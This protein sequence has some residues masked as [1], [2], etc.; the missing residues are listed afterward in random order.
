ML[1]CKYFVTPA[2]CGRGTSCQYSH[3]D[4]IPDGMIARAIS[5]SLAVFE[6]GGQVYKVLVPSDFT[7]IRITGLP[8]NATIGF[9]CILRNVPASADEEDILTT[10]DEK[11]TPE[12]LDFSVA[13]YGASDEMTTRFEVMTKI[14]L[15]V[16]LQIEADENLLIEQYIKI[17]AY[18]STDVSQ[19]FTSLKIEGEPGESFLKAKD[20]LEEILTGAVAMADGRTVWND[21]FMQPKCLNKLKLVEDECGVVIYRDTRKQLRICGS[22]VDIECAQLSLQSMV[23]SGLEAYAIVL[24]RSN[25]RWLSNGGFK[26][27]VSALGKDVASIDTLSSPKK[28][29]ISGGPENYHKA[30]EIL[31]LKSAVTSNFVKADDCIIC[32]CPADTPVRT[33]CGHLYCLQCFENLCSSTASGNKEVS[34]NCAADKRE[35]TLSL[36]E[37]QQYLTSNTFEDLL[38]AS[39]HSYIRRHPEDFHYCPSPD[40]GQIY[41][42]THLVK[43]R[44]CAEHL[45]ETCISCHESHNGQTCD[46]HCYDHISME[47]RNIGGP[48]ADENEDWEMDADFHDDRNREAAP[49]LGELDDFF[50]EIPADNPDPATL[51]PFMRAQ[52]QRLQER[53]EGEPFHRW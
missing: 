6:D 15:A 14:Y 31:N 10:M 24:N 21:Y 18:P 5:G 39:F 44:A 17:R 1:P 9:L 12:K 4:K 53:L 3:D 47:H 43:S 25:F 50:D 28:L 36:E 38:E 51:N 42:V 32:W 8:Q 37:I 33:H 30:M 45:T 46:E 7:T 2:G 13:S 20:K 23:A 52:L 34:I 27:M 29:L 49:I 11:H 19:K 22:P 40:C 35:V 26:Q 41:R 16:Q 48:F